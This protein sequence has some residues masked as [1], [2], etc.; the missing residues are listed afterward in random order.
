MLV[1]FR[2]IF[3]PAPQAFSWFEPHTAMVDPPNFFLLFSFHFQNVVSSGVIEFGQCLS[4][5]MHLQEDLGVCG[6][7]ALLFPQQ[8][9]FLHLLGHGKV[10]GYLRVCRV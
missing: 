10:G 7:A 1:C 5:C 9:T 4:I 2:C 8:V 3:Q 6:I